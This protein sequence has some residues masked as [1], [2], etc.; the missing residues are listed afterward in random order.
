MSTKSTKNKKLVLILL[1]HK[2]KHHYLYRFNVNEFI[3]EKNIKVEIHQLIDFINPKFKKAFQ[4]NDKHKTLKIFKT[5]KSWIGQMKNIKK[6]YGKD[7][8]I[9]NTVQSLSMIS[10]RVNF[11]LKKKNFKT[12]DYI[13][14]FSLANTPYKKLDSKEFLNILIFNQKK[15]YNFFKIKFFLYLGKL[16][17]FYPDYSIKTGQ[18]QYINK[19][20]NTKIIYGNSD[21]FN[22][23][24]SQKK[25]NINI[26]KLKKFGLF[27]EAPTPLFEGDT[28]ITKD[29]SKIFGDPKKWIE[30]LNIFFNFLENNLKILIKIAPHPK[31]FHK[32]RFPDYYFGR[33]IIK[34]NLNDIARHSEL[35]ISRSSTA[36]GYAVMHNKPSLFLTTNKIMQGPKYKYQ[37]ILSSEFGTKP[38][39]IDLNIN[40]FQLKKALKINKKKYERYKLQY[41]TSRLDKKN[42]FQLIKDLFKNL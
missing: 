9:I 8:I 16:F 2:F 14:K 3:N 10:F 39:N 35:F 41:L 30:R 33:E 4:R 11:F 6:I 26:K 23:F 7:I 19:N 40:S 38:I 13:Y 34:Y 28:F 21:D 27:L 17:N 20:K 25:I 15:I 31:V 18:F 29:D 5:Y 24:L 32:N 12:L 1:A 42:N 37:K 22:V 36:M